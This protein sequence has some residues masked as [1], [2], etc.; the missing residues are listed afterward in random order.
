MRQPHLSDRQRYTEQILHYITRSIAT[1]DLLDTFA[2]REDREFYAPIYGHLPM[3]NGPDGQK[4]SKR[5]GAV[6]VLQYQEDG[7]L[8]DAIINY[9]ARLGVALEGEHRNT[10]SNAERWNSRRLLAAPV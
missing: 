3:I 10:W 5:H 8:P 2:P 4:L 9:L 6:S 7:Y 1:G